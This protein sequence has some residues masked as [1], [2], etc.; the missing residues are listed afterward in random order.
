MQ[1]VVSKSIPEAF[2]ARVAEDPKKILFSTF[3]SS[4]L[5]ISNPGKNLE[6]VDL[7]C[8]QALAQASRLAHYLIGQGIGRGQ[9]VAIISEKRPEF[10][11][12]AISILMTGASVVLIY[13]TDGPDEVAFKL[14]DSGARFAFADTT[15]NADKVT[16]ASVGCRTFTI[17][18]E[19]TCTS[20]KLPEAKIVTFDK[21]MYQGNHLLFADIVND[22]K[23]PETPPANIN[24]IKPEDEAYIVYTGGTTGGTPKGVIHTHAGRLI[25]VEQ[26]FSMGLVQ[27]GW[28]TFLMLNLAHAFLQHIQDVCLFKQVRGIFPAILTPRDYTDPTELRAAQRALSLHCLSKANAEVVPIVPLALETIEK[29]IRAKVG[30]DATMGIWREN[31]AGASHRFKTLAHGLLAPLRAHV[32]K[33]VVGN[34]FEYFIS[35]GAPLPPTLARKFEAL[36]MPVLNGYGMTE[37]GTVV[38]CCTPQENKLGTVGKLTPGTEYKLVTDDRGFQTLQ[39]KGPSISPGYLK[40]PIANEKTFKDGWLVVSDVASVDPEGYLSIHG[41]ADDVLALTS[42]E[43][44][45]PEEIEGQL[46][47][48]QYISD[49]V[50]VGHARRFPIALV[51][52]N[53]DAVKAWAKKQGYE[54]NGP[55]AQNPHVRELVEQRVLQANAEAMKHHRNHQ[56]LAG[57]VIVNESFTVENGL[58]TKATL[59]LLRHEVM[60]K[61][62]AVIEKL[63]EELENGAP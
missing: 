3:R 63:F 37:F 16:Q 2:C 19:I 38:A 57:F 60:R 25:N 47:L 45:Y 10:T 48:S 6:L 42:G 5:S 59:K 27:P 22:Q 58:R 20:T 12:A 46:K 23:I 41:R 8:D 50:V 56:R 61:Y 9:R 26:T 36:G 24:A 43:K 14:F 33:K 35:G 52:L 30:F 51:S 7:S 31:A 11:L 62:K 17:R 39:L 1:S 18:E 15:E 28:S 54:L 13:P 53:E 40:R 32:T 34:N 49:A 55:L 4:S 21:E 29:K 44:V